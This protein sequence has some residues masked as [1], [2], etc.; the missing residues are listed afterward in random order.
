MEV[1]ASG[2]ATERASD[3]SESSFW[4]AWRTGD[5]EESTKVD[6]NGVGTDWSTKVDENGVGTD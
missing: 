5:C 1:S 3:A 2:F 6:E 4:S